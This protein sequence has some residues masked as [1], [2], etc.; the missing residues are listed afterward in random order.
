LNQVE[1][2]STYGPTKSTGFNIELKRIVY[3]LVQYWYLVALCLFL[4]LGT[5]ILKIRYAVPIYQVTSSLVMK[6]QE[7]SSEGRLLYNNIYHSFL[8]YYSA[9]T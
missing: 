5:A 7:E 6:E 1:E 8:S 3:R 9:Y 4:A 2:H